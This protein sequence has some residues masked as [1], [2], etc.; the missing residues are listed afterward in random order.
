MWNPCL[1]SVSWRNF[2]WTPNKHAW[3]NPW[4]KWCCIDVIKD[5]VTSYAWHLNHRN[6]MSFHL[7]P[8]ERINEF[9]TLAVNDARIFLVKFFAKSWFTFKT[10][11]TWNKECFQLRHSLHISKTNPSFLY[12]WFGNCQ[13]TFVFNDYSCRLHFKS[14]RRNPSLLTHQKSPCNESF[15]KCFCNASSN[16]IS[17]VLC[18]FRFCHD[19]KVLNL[20]QQCLILPSYQSQKSQFCTRILCLS[21]HHCLVCRR[22]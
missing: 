2:R 16:S 12:I 11:W 6:H 15:V 3:K 10:W 17:D 8:L 9:D 22:Q 5:V 14:S 21:F 13:W 1:V 4:T 7:L 18:S 19:T 20:R